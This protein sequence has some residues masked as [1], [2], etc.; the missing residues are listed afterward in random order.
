MAEMLITPLP[1]GACPKC[2]KKQFVVNERTSTYYLT[3]ADGE[4]IDSKEDTHICVG[5]CVNCGK[6]YE[7]FPTREGFIPI[8]PLRKFIY[9]YSKEYIEAHD[10]DMAPKIDNPMIKEK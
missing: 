9:E 10:E 1:K 3:N 8:T 5:Q 4:I 7:M 6:V 2:N